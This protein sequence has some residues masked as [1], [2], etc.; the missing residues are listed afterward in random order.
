MNAIR[1]CL[2]FLCL[3]V[4]GPS[5]AWAAPIF[6]TTTPRAWHSEPGHTLWLQDDTGA[7]T[8]DD[9]RS[10]DQDRRFE[11]APCFAKRSRGAQAHWSC[12]WNNAPMRATGSWPRRPPPLK[13]VQFFGPFDSMGR[14]LAPHT[15]L[16][17]VF[18][19][20]RSQ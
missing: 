1:T 5:W 4:A 12:K 18:Q 2:L 19:R 6:W 15:G 13:D 8:L 16:S 9:V 7:L 17:Q 10:A 3:L 14:T 11:P 20:A